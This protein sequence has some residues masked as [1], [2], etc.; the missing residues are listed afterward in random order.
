MPYIIAFWK[1]FCTFAFI[2]QP[3]QV[4]NENKEYNNVGFSLVGNTT[5]RNG[6]G[7]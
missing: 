5:N 2:L 7:Y 6:T 4:S 3:K 1:V